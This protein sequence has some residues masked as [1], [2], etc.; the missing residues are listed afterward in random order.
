[1]PGEWSLK[2][3]SNVGDLLLSSCGISVMRRP[4]Q[5]WICAVCVVVGLAGC[6]S[7]DT[8]DGKSGYRLGSVPKPAAK[9][10][11]AETEVIA[12]LKSAE[13]VVF[14]DKEGKVELVRFIEPEVSD[15]L[16]AKV[17]SLSS[18]KTLEIYYIKGL[19]RKGFA[20]IAKMTSLET[21]ILLCEGLN[22]DWLEPLA[23][24]TG[25]K[26]LI[27]SGNRQLTAEGVKHLAGLT[28]LLELRLGDTKIGDSGVES[29]AGLTSLE[30]LELKRADVTDAGVAHLKGMTKLQELQLS[31]RGRN[32]D[33]I[34]SGITDASA[35]VIGAMKQLEILDL[36]S[37]N[38]TDAG[39]TKLGELKHLKT[40]V[41]LSSI[42]ITDEGVAKFKQMVPGC[43]VHGP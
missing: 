25:L 17:T 15:E 23:S 19:T 5:F 22:D 33:K 29:I 4:N 24:L 42:K 31:G 36:G 21:L 37:T 28:N 27:L 12:A 16:F 11:A 39:L 38:L 32:F 26:S 2:F 1:M 41:L 35:E 30:R 9:P 20:P 6:G 18:V 43:Q 7:S 40:L 34:D 8:T 14:L 13:A 10:S 3:L